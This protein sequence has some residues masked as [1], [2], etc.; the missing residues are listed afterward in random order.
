MLFSRRFLFEYE[1]GSFGHGPGPG[2]WV[3]PAFAI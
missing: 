1:A 2:S 3:V